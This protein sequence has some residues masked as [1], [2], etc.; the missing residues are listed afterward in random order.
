MCAV[1]VVLVVLNVLAGR[2]GYILFPGC[3]ALPL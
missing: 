1:K 3:V 2:R